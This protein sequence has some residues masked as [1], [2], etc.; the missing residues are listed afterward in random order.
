MARCPHGFERAA[1]PCASCG[2]TA[3]KI[4]SASRVRRRG[5]PYKPGERPTHPGFQD[6]TGAVIDGARV[7]ARLA[8]DSD[9]GA[10][11]SVELPCGH[12]RAIKA[13]ALRGGQRKRGFLC[14]ECRGHQ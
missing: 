6:L 1:V 5:G 4:G 11:W 2:D 8:N 7:L 3:K 12:V 9:G 14:A 13:I 10:V